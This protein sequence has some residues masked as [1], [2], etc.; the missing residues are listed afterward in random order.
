M[1]IENYSFYIKILLKK[2]VGNS[3]LYIST[4]IYQKPL[5]QYFGRYINISLYYTKIAIIG[6]MCQKSTFFT[7]IV[8]K[9][10]LQL[11]MQ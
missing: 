5:E 3:Q 1:K 6:K 9:L 10:L 7:K 4:S 2:I 8:K 11:L